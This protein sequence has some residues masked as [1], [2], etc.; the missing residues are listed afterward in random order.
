MVGKEPRITDRM[1]A[2][3]CQRLRENKRIRRNLP[4][5]GR[6]HIDRQLPFLCLFRQ[7]VGRPEPDMQKLATGE[8]SYIICSARR[9]LHA[10]L[11]K[12][13]TAILQTQMDLFGTT[14]VMEIWSGP[15]IKTEEPVSTELLEPHF[16]IYAPRGS[17]QSLFANDLKRTLERVTIGKKRA[18]VLMSRV[19]VWY[20][21]RLPPILPPELSQS[22]H[23][24]TCGLEIRPIF[25]DPH[26]GLVFPAVLRDL[27]RRFSVALR[28]ALFT[29]S[30]KKTSYQPAHF[31]SIGRRSVV[32]A[33]RDVDA[34]IAASA[35]QFDFLLQATP[36]NTH[37]AWLEFR[38]SR[39]QKV[40]EFNYRPL[41]ADPL[42]LKRSVYR[43]PVENVEDPALESLFR[44]KIEELDRQI[45]MLQDINTPKFLHGSLQLYGQADEALLTTALE[46]LGLRPKKTRRKASL[47]L[48]R[49]LRLQSKR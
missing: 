20:P 44:D 5:F 34:K 19:K 2:T 40:P 31:H 35:S 43:A 16:K 4:Q 17:A 6:I 8:A 11:Q 12:L 7:R 18:T 39:Y 45:T 42:R 9:S 23:I 14:L 49:I 24:I 26:S 29:F 27:Q 30:V 41:P 25:K 36:T 33:V 47:H 3:L 22:P 46:I 13:I 38:R 1:V 21:K 15:P 28:R 10:D 32:K 37:E 48:R